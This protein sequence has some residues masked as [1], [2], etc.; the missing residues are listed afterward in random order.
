MLAF[1]GNLNAI[2]DDPD[3]QY[4][5]S[6]NTGISPGGVAFTKKT[7]FPIDAQRKMTERVYKEAKEKAAVDSVRPRMKADGY[8]KAV[9]IERM[10][11]S[12]TKRFIAN[13]E[14]YDKMVSYMQQVRFPRSL[15]ANC[16]TT[17]K[18]YEPNFPH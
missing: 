15:I 2:L 13:N 16:T 3:D 17:E 4:A 1:S 12:E 7:L 10:Y 18:H 11:Q 8:D 6:K 5:Q 14:A 9:P